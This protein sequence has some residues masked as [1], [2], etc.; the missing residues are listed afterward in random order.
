MA[1]T[2]KQGLNNQD[3]MYINALRTGR[4]D[5]SHKFFYHEIGGIIHRIR[6]EVFHGHVEFDE[7]VNELYLYLSKDNWSKLDGFDAKNGCRLRAWII[8]VA[9]RYF[10]SIRQRLLCQCN[11]AGWTDDRKTVND[12]FRIQ[13]AIDVTT[14][15][16]RMPNKRYAEII[17]LLL[18]DGYSVSDVADMLDTR[19]ENVYNLKH[20]AIRQFIELY[21][22]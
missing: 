3:A 22:R 9:W 11:K 16:N 12:E 19:V 15:L 21:G 17:R 13:I 14:V 10:I 8:P 6:T 5:M 18:V 2:D 20:R 4:N 7:M 1:T